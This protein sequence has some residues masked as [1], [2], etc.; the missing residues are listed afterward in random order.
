MVQIAAHRPGDFGMQTSLG[1]QPTEGSCRPRSIIF[2][3]VRCQS[4]LLASSALLH[5]SVALGV[6][7]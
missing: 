7:M 3:K 2:R 1:M 4:M 6:E 5:K